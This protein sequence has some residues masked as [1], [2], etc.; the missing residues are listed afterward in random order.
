MNVVVTSDG[1]AI[2]FMSTSTSVEGVTSLSFATSSVLNAGQYLVDVVYSLSRYPA[3][4]KVVSFNLTMYVLENP[5][6][7]T[8]QS[9]MVGDIVK[10]ISSDLFSITPASSSLV[11]TYTSTLDDGSPL[12][13]FI[14]GVQTLT[15]YEFAVFS[16]QAS[17]AGSYDIKIIVQVGGT[18]QSTSLST[19]FTLVVTAPPPNI[20]IN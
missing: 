8:Q 12:P 18:G 7:L 20:I 13:S 4:S 15:A 9:Y 3:I 5:P 14:S 6:A 19:S 10:T 16:S 1:Q 2:P 17:S 11:F